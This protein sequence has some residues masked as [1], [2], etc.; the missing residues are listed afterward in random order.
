MYMFEPDKTAAEKQE[1]LYIM[2]KATKAI[3]RAHNTI[4]REQPT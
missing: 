3:Q 4:S 2:L 1:I